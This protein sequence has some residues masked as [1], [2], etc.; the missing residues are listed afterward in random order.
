MQRLTCQ[1]CK[2]KL[3]TKLPPGMVSKCPKCL[4]P[5]VVPGAIENPFAFPS[6]KTVAIIDD[7]KVPYSV[8]QKRKAKLRRRIFYGGVVALALVVVYYLFSGHGPLAPPPST[9]VGVADR[10]NSRGVKFH[11]VECRAHQ[12]PAIYLLPDEDWK[13]ERLD[14]LGQSYLNAYLRG[15]TDGVVV[16]V[17]FL[18]AKEASEEAGA[19]R[20]SFAYGRFLIYGD[21]KLVKEIQDNL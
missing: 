13:K 4:G 16:V 7:S 12:L 19:K 5:I 8:Q 17:Q 9:C 21:A 20:N 18:D 10:I 14:G 15:R 11:W 3:L 6:E 1:K 2:T